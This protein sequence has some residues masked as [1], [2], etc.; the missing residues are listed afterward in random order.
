MATISFDEMA[1]LP[2]PKGLP[3]IELPKISLTKLLNNDETEA[4]TLFDICT[5][6]GFFY[7]DLMD[8]PKGRRFWE[9]AVRARS[10]GQHVMSTLSMEEKD[11]FLKRPE[12]GILDRGCVIALWFVIEYSNVQRI[13]YQ[14]TI[15]DEN[16]QTKFVESINVSLIVVLNLWMKRELIVQQAAKR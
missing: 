16:G 5:R 1:P 11:T 9:G 10:I 6:T 14:S 15:R 3:T 4:Q 13:R 7:L 12:V 2:L 8:H